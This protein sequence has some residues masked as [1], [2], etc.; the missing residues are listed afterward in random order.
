MYDLTECIFT[1]GEIIDELTIDEEKIAEFS[2][3]YHK[4]LLRSKDGNFYL[5]ALGDFSSGK[6]TL[7][8]AI[9]NRKLLKV[10]HAATTAVPTYIYKGKSS[11]V[12]IKALCKGGKKYDLTSE[13][14]LNKFENKYGVKLPQQ[15]D[16]IISLLTADKDLASK[17]N[18]YY[19]HPRYQPR[20]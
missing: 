2:K 17:R 14:D 11:D 19:R 1:I 10:A 6:S 12:V 3:Q 20:S 7:I 18:L 5:S 15:T 9:I 16:E 13:E 8:N 4:I